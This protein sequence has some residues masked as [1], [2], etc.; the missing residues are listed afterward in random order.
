[1]KDFSVPSDMLE[2][3][4]SSIGPSTLDVFS[5][6][7]LDTHGMG[8]STSILTNSMNMLNNFP[9]LNKQ[10]IRDYLGY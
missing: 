10:S 2:T 4:K 9:S 8:L 6:P 7:L 1:M 3:P 5:K